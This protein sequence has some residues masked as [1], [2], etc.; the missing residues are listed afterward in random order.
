MNC[1]GM[2]GAPMGYVGIVGTACAGSIIPPP[3]GLAYFINV[4][5]SIKT[6]SNVSIFSA[7][8]LLRKMAVRWSMAFKKYING[9]FNQYGVWHLQLATCHMKAVVEARNYLSWIPFDQYK[10]LMYHSWIDECFKL[11][12]EQFFEC[13]PISNASRWQIDIPIKGNFP[14]RVGE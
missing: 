12:Q 6:L 14:Q 7:G 9:S 5:A 13:I 4:I 1:L 8:S 11:F 3:L 10:L 2:M